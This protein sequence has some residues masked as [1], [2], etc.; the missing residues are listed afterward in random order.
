MLFRHY[1]PTTLVSGIVLF[2]TVQ[3]HAQNPYQGPTDE[4]GDPSAQ[5]L[6]LM[7]GN[8][9][10]LQISNR[11]SFG[12]WP[13]PL[14][15]LWP[16]DATGLNT[17]DNFNL[18]I[19]NMEFIK[20][21]STCAFDS[22]PVTDEGEIQTLGAQG[23]LDTLW[24]AQSSSIQPGF[25]DLDP[26]GTIEWGFDPVFGYFNKSNDYPAMS[27]IPGSWPTEG[28]PSTGL[29]TKW[30][31][32]W[33]GRF[34]RGVR[35]ADLEAF[36]VCNDAQDL[37]NIESRNDAP[38]AVR[39]YPRPGVKIGDLHPDEISVQ[40][41]WDWGGLGL[42]TEVRAYQWNNQ[43]TRDAVFFE[44]NIA[45]T[46]DYDLTRA[47]FGFYLDA[48]NGNKSPTSA[49]EDQIGYWDKSQN[50]TYT[51]SISGSGFGG[52]TPAVSGWAFLESP[53]VATDGI[54]NDG[55]GMVDER[56]DN[57]A[58]G[59]WGGFSGVI[60][61]HD[62][63]LKAIIASRDTA[64]F[65]AFFGYKSLEDVPAV[66]Q[67]EWWPG[68]ED[69]DWKDGVDANGDG[70]YEVNEDAGDDIGLDGVRPGDLN[71]F[72]PDADGTECNHRPD[73][74][75]GIG[76]EP[77]FASTDVAES[78]MLGLTSF[79]M[80]PHPQ[81]GSPQIKYDQACY[82]TLAAQRLVP[83]FGTPSN[84]YCAFG[85]GTFRLKK[86]QTERLSMCNV[87]SYDDLS[88]LNDASRNHP[89]PSLFAK[90]KVV[91]AVYNNDYRFSQPPLLPT[92][93]AAAGDGVVYLSW[94]DK[95][96]KL[97]RQ[98][99][100]GG[101]NDFEGYKLYKSTDKYFQDAEVIRDAFGNPAGRKPIFQ[102]DLVDSIMGFPSY[103]AT[104]GG[105]LYYLGNDSGLKH[106]FVDN[107]VQNGRTYY[108]AI[109]AYNYG[110]PETGG[111][112]FSV[113]IPPAENN[114][115]IDLDEAGN[116]RSVGANVQIVVP[117]QPSAGY[118]PAN[119]KLSDPA[120][121][122]SKG[123]VRPAVFNQNV[124]KPGHVYKL[125]FTT[126]TVS[127]YVRSAALRQKREGYIATSGYSVSDT[128]A[129][130][131]ALYQDTPASNAANWEK[132]SFSATVNYFRPAS[133]G[134]TSD[135]I[136][137]VQLFIQPF[138]SVPGFDTLHSG[139][140][141][142]SAP[143]VV[144]PNLV[145]SPYFAYNYSIVF[146]D[147]TL[148]HSYR[149]KTTNKSS[150]PIFSAANAQLASSRVLLNQSFPFHVINRDCPD[151][152]GYQGFEELDVVVQDVNLNGVYDPGIDTVLIGYPVKYLAQLVFPNTIFGM[153]LP[154]AMP[155][156]GDVY[157][158]KFKS[159]MRD[160]LY[161]T[162]TENAVVASKLNEDM[163]EIK[164]V[165]NPYI[166]TNTMEPYLSNRGLNQQRQLLFTHIPAKCTL[167]IFTSSGVFIREIDV[168]NPAADGTIHWDMLTKEGL[169]IA[170]GVYIYYIKSGVTGKEKLGKFAVI[171]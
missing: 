32:E 3:V 136:D 69:A 151:S 76:A 60:K 138:F 15:S 137:G 6:G 141:T 65:M 4:A 100:L 18:I 105:V 67:G 61:G 94:D 96:D 106:Y 1:V 62:A 116:I 161:Y 19:G 121:V 40:K 131:V 95:S 171:K 20:K 52:G 166:V 108:Y 170:A 148:E 23:Q 71:Y 92:L 163:A 58:E 12:G 104:S 2:F 13:S 47:V 37:E 139:W 82:D 59:P 21:C 160:S 55:D 103:S 155:K 99:F 109:V 157:N 70:I 79:V 41:G 98:P 124:V 169:E 24:N 81:Q 87:N 35:Y 107:N 25:M 140:Q 10:S 143:I 5:R 16:N 152:S 64:K 46:S 150:T 45:N 83:F 80:F 9:V 128:T 123:T 154:G 129:G 26:T 73:Y 54:D 135:V 162:V 125:K 84:L 74:K 66:R 89:A 34:G 144:T 44:Y 115:I 29:Q 156:P 132:T 146:D 130:N 7:N 149:T 57:Q 86:G 122:Q 77:D 88:G 33:D 22:V 111:G 85:S 14:V 167:K 117:H 63:V 118:V 127:A 68:D 75:E 126:D 53:G 78:D 8:R 38:L 145:R 142:G 119:I 43:Q 31:G 97:T 17:F 30:P 153:I 90:K 11:V 72:G 42:R 91:D 48:A 49:A 51:W 159:A 112:K 164:V 101:I 93:S 133:A 28:W 114:T 134:M 102:C 168:D 147:T 158:V 165:P 39:Y 50:L 56:R 36:W 110:M 27:N 113:S 120:N